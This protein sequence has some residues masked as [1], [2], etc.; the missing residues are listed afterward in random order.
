M[1]DSDELSCSSDEEISTTTAVSFGIPKVKEDFFKRL[2]K[3]KSVIKVQP[4]E[5]LYSECSNLSFLNAV[6]ISLYCE[7][8]RSTSVYQYEDLYHLHSAF[9]FNKR[10]DF[11]MTIN[12]IKGFLNKNTDKNMRINLFTIG[13][14]TPSHRQQLFYSKSIGPLDGYQVRF[15]SSWEK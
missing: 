5:N 11:P 14:D 9:N 2:M 6:S 4:P 3:L 8:S 13:L 1:S 15:E 10:T 7:R 12:R